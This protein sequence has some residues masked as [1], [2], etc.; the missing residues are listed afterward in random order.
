M[1]RVA[2]SS[3]TTK[4]P[5]SEPVPLNKV[6]Q[7]NDGEDANTTL[8]VELNGCKH[9]AIL[10]SGARIAIATKNTWEQCEKLAL[11]QLWM[12]LQLA[13]GHIQRPIGL[14]ERVLVT[15]CDI[16]YQHTF[17]VVNFGQNPNYDVVLGKPFMRQLKMIQDW[18]FN[19]IYLW[20]DSSITRVN[21]RYHSF[22][23]I[24]RTRVEDFESA[25]TSYA[26][27]SWIGKS[28][29]L[30]ICGTSKNGDTK[31]REGKETSNETYILEHK[32]E[33]F[34]WLDILATIAICTNNV[35]PTLF[36]NEEGYDVIPLQMVNV[37]PIK[38]EISLMPKPQ[39]K[40]SLESHVRHV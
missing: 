20:K 5:K 16:E 36:C 17:A 39:I 22:K 28:A 26:K 12:K 27:S 19:Y 38:E 34:G 9:I 31:E 18:G 10:D 30:W 21:M 6:E 29:H 32:F 35:N 1:E 13:D 7:Y 11:R 4:N 14:L 40:P 33:P 24:A 3:I 23:D 15:T 8:P 37:L 2:T 25:T